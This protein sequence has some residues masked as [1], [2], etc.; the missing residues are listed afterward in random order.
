MMARSRNRV[1][2]PH[3]TEQ[4]LKSLQAE[5]TQFMGARVV[6][7]VLVVVV[8]V[9]VDVEVLAVVVVVDEANVLLELIPD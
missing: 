8:V 2:L 1:P 6:V 3:V 7:V 5:I 9:V 4:E